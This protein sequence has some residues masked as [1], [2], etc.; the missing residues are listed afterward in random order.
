ML[1]LDRYSGLKREFKNTA[2]KDDGLE[3]IPV[4]VKLQGVLGRF[5]V[6]F[7]SFG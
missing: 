7:M 2:K 3:K 5:L 1:R 4:L 6:V